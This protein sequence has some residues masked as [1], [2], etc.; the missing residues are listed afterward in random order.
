MYQRLRIGELNPTLI[1]LFLSDRSIEVP[2]GVV[3]DV[4]IQVDR[5]VYPIDFIVLDTKEGDEAKSVPIILG[6]PFLTTSNALIDRRNG[7]IQIT[8]GI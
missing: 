2:R 1:T 4:L 5:F 7:H 3:E 8:F 6:R